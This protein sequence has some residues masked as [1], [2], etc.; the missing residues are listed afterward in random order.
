MWVIFGYEEQTFFRNVWRD[1]CRKIRVITTN[2]CVLSYFSQ[3][4]KYKVCLSKKKYGKAWKFKF[5][6]VVDYSYHIKMKLKAHP[7]S[8]RNICFLFYYYTRAL[9]IIEFPTYIRLAIVCS[10]PNSS[11]KNEWNASLK[12]QYASLILH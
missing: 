6:F 4:P 10:E 1:V 9:S 12:L 11:M 5:N 2:F 7:N 8:I 3:T